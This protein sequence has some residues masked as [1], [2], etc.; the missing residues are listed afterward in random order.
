MDPLR[1]RT[2]E[3][4]P[5]DEEL[6]RRLAAGHQEALASL[7]ARYAALIFGVAAQSL[8]WPAAEEIVQDVFVAVWRR[9]K[10]Y[11]PVRGEVRPWIL[12][13]ARARVSNEFRRRG[14]R[15]VTVIDPEGLQLAAVADKAPGPDEDLWQ[16][17]RRT[18]VRVAVDALPPSQRQALSLAFFEELSHQQ[19]SAYLGV[20]LGT[21]KTRIRTGVQRLRTAL[22]PLVAAVVV[23]L[24]A[25]LVTLGL[26]MRE[27]WEQLAR[28]DAALEIVS[29]SDVTTV[30][31]VAATGT[32]P[33]THGVY[34]TRPGATLA[35]LTLSRFAP[36]PEGQ[37]YRIWARYGG[38]WQSL[39]TTHLD[40]DGHAVL[41]VDQHA[42]GGP[43]ALE[44]TLEQEGGSST[45][46]DRVVIAWPG[47]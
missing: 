5:P 37:T 31:L 27:Q 7:H 12:Q 25:G 22:R 3:D 6:M 36:A 18:A 10:T 46:G 26:R 13:I 35:V 43:E 1:L 20:P 34:R 8:D 17:Y 28:R 39:G 23:A 14:R 19:I 9:A 40:R 24:I 32:S 38:T 29:S 21:T 30:R 11:D 44:V 47:P 16:E 4:E 2:G 41:I 33:E 15:P 45:P 42:N